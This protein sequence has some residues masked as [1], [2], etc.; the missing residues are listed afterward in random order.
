LLTQ[1]YSNLADDLSRQCLLD[2]C[3]FRIGQNLAYASKTHHE[4]QYF[5]DLTLPLLAGRR[6]NYVD[7]GAYNGDSYMEL[8]KYVDIGQ[9]YLF[10]P[11]TENYNLLAVA[12]QNRP[13]SVICLPLAL[14]DSY[15][16]TAF[17][18]GVGEG[19]A[20]GDHGSAR[21]ATVALDQVFPK[22]TIDFI[23]FDVE[24]AEVSALL[25]ARELIQRCRPVLAISLYHRP[26]DIWEIPQTLLSISNQYL[27]YIRQHFFNSF[28]SV[29][30]A[31]PR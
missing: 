29:L 2:I 4:T 31:I 7:A 13:E 8:S 3:E 10:E 15:Q 1:V 30:Y 14:A 19:A 9:A 26:T 23:K 28:D 21:I 5:N 20:I 12:M 17:N 6:I 27:F 25:G 18:A 11:D 16:I 24:G 22:L